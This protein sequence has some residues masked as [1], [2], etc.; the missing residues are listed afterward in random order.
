MQP[1]KTMSWG[2]IGIILR[3]TVFQ[4]TK[5][6]L[7]SVSEFRRQKSSP[8]SHSIS[9]EESFG[10][11]SEV[12]AEFSVHQV[13][14]CF[15]RGCSPLKMLSVSVVWTKLTTL[16]KMDMRSFVK[17]TVGWSWRLNGRNV[18]FHSVKIIV[19]LVSSVNRASRLRRDL[20]SVRRVNS[21]G[22]ER[23]TNMA[24]CSRMYLELVL[25]TRRVLWTSCFPPLIAIVLADAVLQTK[26]RSVRF[27][28]KS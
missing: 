26:N 28:M 24:Q 10:G 13:D 1:L 25:G 9:S 6:S 18:S 14:S 15:A 22:G 16:L 4:N 11:G 2:F 8:K 7:R 12:E 27:R 3:R 17:S 5:R 20:P 21:C 19:V 23:S